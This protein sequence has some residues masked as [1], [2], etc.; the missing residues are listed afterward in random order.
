MFS[1]F[2]IADT[3]LDFTQGGA[4]F[5]LATAVGVAFASVAGLIIAIALDNW[6]SRRQAEKTAMAVE[7]QIFPRKAA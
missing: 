5:S 4:P 3:V 7:E 6:W 1:L 2:P